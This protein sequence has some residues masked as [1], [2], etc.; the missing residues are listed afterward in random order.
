[1]V[2]DILDKLTLGQISFFQESNEWLNSL[3]DS[4]REGLSQDLLEAGRAFD[5]MTGGAL[6]ME[7]SVNQSVGAV[8]GFGKAVVEAGA[9]AGDTAQEIDGLG[10]SLDGLNAN[11]EFQMSIGGVEGV[12]EMVKQAGWELDQIPEETITKL[13]ASP[14]SASFYTTW[15]ELETAFADERDVSVGATADAPSVG[16]TSNYLDLWLPRDRETKARAE[17]DAAS[18]ANTSKQLDAMATDRNVKVSLDAKEAEYRMELLKQQFGLMQSNVEW[19]AKLDIAEVEANAQIVAALA[20]T[21]GEAFASSAQIISSAIDALSKLESGFD[22]YGERAFLEGVIERELNLRERAMA[23]TEA[24]VQ[25]QI[26][27]ME[28]KIRQMASGEAMVTIDGAGLQP[29]LEAF[30]W[31]ILSAIQ[32]RVNEEGHAMLFGI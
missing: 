19:K 29:H 28:A 7:D 4:L 14:D 15:Q 31:E 32:T 25:R 9:H 13:A 23:A 5:T 24:L 20:G 21:M 11:T 8:L 30:M 22:L 1:M 16:A 3:G 12:I 2:N 27:F 6:Q 18:V 10:R 26:D 17:A